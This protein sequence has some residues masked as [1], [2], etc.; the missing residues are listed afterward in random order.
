MV[1]AH[2]GSGKKDTNGS[3]NPVNSLETISPGKVK[4]VSWVKVKGK[5]FFTGKVNACHCL[6]HVRYMEDVNEL[7]AVLCFVLCPCTICRNIN[8]VSII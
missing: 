7:L 2:K 5:Q 6:P 8:C 1:I 3:I 4:T